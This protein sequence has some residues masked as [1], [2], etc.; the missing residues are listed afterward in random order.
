MTKYKGLIH[1]H[2]VYEVIVDAPSQALA[3]ETVEDLVIQEDNG[4][5]KEDLNAG[6]TDV[7]EVEEVTED[8]I[9]EE[10]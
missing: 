8:D 1:V 9:I 5:W 3:Q 6:W 4:R 10:D 2:T 7:I